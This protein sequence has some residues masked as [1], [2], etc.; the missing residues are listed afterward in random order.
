[1]VQN[2]L[3]NKLLRQVKVQIRGLKNTR[4]RHT[5]TDGN[6]K[7]PMCFGSLIFQ[8]VLCNHSTTVV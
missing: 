2:V 8:N 1:M 5:L 3:N 7:W 4:L 6:K